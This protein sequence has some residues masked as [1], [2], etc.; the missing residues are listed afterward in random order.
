[1][2]TKGNRQITVN[3]F[4]YALVICMN[5]WAFAF[6]EILGTGGMMAVSLVIVVCLLVNIF[7][8]QTMKFSM[9][10]LLMVSLLLVY[11]QL[12]PNTNLKRA[13][14]FCYI[15]ISCFAAL[16]AVDT[17]KVLRYVTYFSVL[18]LVFTTQIFAQLSHQK[19]IY[20]AEQGVMGLSYAIL[21]IVIA[22]LMHFI[23]YRKKANFL[24]KICYVTDVVYAFILF[25]YANRGVVLTLL[26]VFV[27]LYI[28][29]FGSKSSKRNNIFRVIVVLFITT[30]I[31]NNYIL[32][33]EWMN[34]ILLDS[35]IKLDFVRKTLKIQTDIS[36]GR[37][38]I[39]EYVVENIFKSPILG[40]GV[41]TITY[42][43]NG[44][45]PY[46]HNFIL[47]LFYDGGILLA[48]PVL[49]FVIKMVWS[50]L[51]HENN[52]KTIFLIFFCQICLP[53]MFFSTDMWKNPSFWLVLFN[54]IQ[55]YT[56]YTES[57]EK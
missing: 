53:K 39:T 35:D 42:N 52:D 49:F 5:F 34:N 17:E 44:M 25:M 45:I 12:S 50:A 24:L 21:P 55:S 31:I 32:I 23:Y 19:G 30:L 27:L 54:Y 56:T 4:T 16:Y 6:G 43:S 11:Y 18:L 10:W 3:S 26:V 15:I 14:F 9:R 28:K 36:N 20:D 47:Q 40:H 51:W 29:K 2:Q 22:G 46:P 8:A 48:V 13:E 41:S 1:M 7:Y 57:E 37:N 38:A 33:L